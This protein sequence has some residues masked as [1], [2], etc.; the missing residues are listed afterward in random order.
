MWFVITCK[1]MGTR[2]PSPPLRSLQPGTTSINHLES[3]L[4]RRRWEPEAPIS[5]VASE[6]AVNARLG[7]ALSARAHRRT[8]KP[9]RLACALGA[10]VGRRLQG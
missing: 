6:C 3:P 2:S 4:Q 5:H 7:P 9:T 8:Q 10:S 1:R